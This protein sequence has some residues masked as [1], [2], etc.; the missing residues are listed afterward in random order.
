M[1][2]EEKK[3]TLLNK[4]NA[5]YVFYYDDKN[6]VQMKN[7]KTNKNAVIVTLAPP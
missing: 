6:K 2:K 1:Y 7:F 4:Y 5:K 3:I